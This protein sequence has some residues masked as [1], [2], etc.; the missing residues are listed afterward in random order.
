MCFECHDVLYV[1]PSILVLSLWGIVML[2]NV[3]VGL[4][5]CSLLSVVR[6]V[7]VDLDGA[8]FSLFC[9]NQFSSCVM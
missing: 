1:T 6:S 7:L 2:F 5:W 4:C 9:D 3:A 8:T